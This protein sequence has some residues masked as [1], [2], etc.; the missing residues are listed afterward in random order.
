MKTW[1]G[2]ALLGALAVSACGRSGGGGSGASAAGQPRPDP[3]AVTTPSPASAPGDCAGGVTVR[4]VGTNP[5]AVSSLVLQPGTSGVVCA[6][7]APACATLAA[8]VATAPIELASDPDPH[9]LFTFEYPPQGLPPDGGPA[10]LVVSFAGGTA[11]VAGH[12]GPLALCGPAVHVP[13]DPR[14]VSRDR[15]AIT[16]YLDV[17]RSVVASASGID[18]VPQVRIFF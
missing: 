13:F 1:L 15:C 6:P 5:G 16:V 2:W 8:S 7:S 9:A 14:R 4:V 17:G 18:L 3:T 11:T 12:T 10:E